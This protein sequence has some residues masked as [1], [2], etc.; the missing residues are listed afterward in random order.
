MYII[1]TK[2][3]RENRALQDIMDAI[4]TY[5]M[6]AEPINPALTGLVLIKTKLSYEEINKILKE[7][8]IRTILSIEKTIKHVKMLGENSLSKALSLLF[9]E[10]AEGKVKIRRVKVRCLGDRKSSENYVR[11]LV[12][13][14]L[15]KYKLIDEKEGKDLILSIVNKYVFIKTIE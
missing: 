9:E 15:A 3:G 1:K 7:Y 11:K 6:E 4:F 12:D 8:P 14:L 2:P 10:L 13:S 5:D